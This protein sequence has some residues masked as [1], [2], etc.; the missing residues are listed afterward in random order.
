[1]QAAT[2]HLCRTAHRLYCLACLDT[3]S[4]PLL[5]MVTESVMKAWKWTAL[6]LTGGVLLQLNTCAVDLAY[7]VMQALATQVV[8]Q[9]LTSATA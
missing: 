4:R 6:V 2:H 7:Y 9:M 1:M 8:S 3:S 5:D